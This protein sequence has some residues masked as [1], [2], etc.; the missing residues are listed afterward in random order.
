MNVELNSTLFWF[1]L[2]YWL[3]GWA[4]ESERRG[5]W[6]TKMGRIYRA[7]KLKAHTNRFGIQMLKSVRSDLDA[8]P[9][10]A[11]NGLCSSIAAPNVVWQRDLR[12]FCKQ[13]DFEIDDWNNF[14][15]LWQFK[16]N[17]WWNAKWNDREK[18]KI[19]F[20]TM[21]EF[22]ANHDTFQW[23]SMREKNVSNDSEE[24]IVISL[25]CCMRMIL[26]FSVR[27]PPFHQKF[28]FHDNFYFILI[29][30]CYFCVI[31]TTKILNTK[32]L[33]C[34]SCTQFTQY[35]RQNTEVTTKK[36]N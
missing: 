8:K 33:L 28:K 13:I 19:F 16:G 36:P 17:R 2:I 32:N 34:S 4:I 20:V 1:E 15:F 35:K 23:K 18:K 29:I 10:S 30:C 12:I 31:R 3:I 25:I 5:F 27:I 11:Y 14:V 21:Y 7:T 24:K 22:T 26:Q 6:I 9:K